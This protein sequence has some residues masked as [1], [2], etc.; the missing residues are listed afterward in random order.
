MFLRGEYEG[1]RIDNTTPEEVD[2]LIE[3]Y[4]RIQPREIMIYSIDRQTPAQGLEKVSR[5]EL[6]EIARR[7]SLATDI[8]VQ[9]A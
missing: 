4:R 5:E 8:K 2:A 9:V 1:V 6:E 3:A 7:I